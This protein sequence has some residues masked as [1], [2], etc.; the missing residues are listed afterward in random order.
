MLE[1]GR[2]MRRP[3]LG[4]RW[5][6]GTFVV[7]CVAV[8]CVELGLWQLRR[9][10][11]RRAFNASVERALSSDA[12]PLGDVLT[13]AGG[14]AA[15][16]AYRRVSASGTYDEDREVV[17]FG[18]TLDGEPGNEL[19]TP[20]V[21]HGGEAI[22]VDRGWVPL[23]MQT[24]PVG[25]A[26]PPPGRVSVTGILWPAEATTDVDP[27]APP[28]R[29]LAKVDLSRLEPQL[30]YA[31]PPVYLWLRSQRP[32]SSPLPRPVPL[33]PLDEGPHLSYAVQW[34]VFAAVA[35]VGFGVLVRRELTRR[36]RSPGDANGRAGAGPRGESRSER[37][38]PT[39]GARAP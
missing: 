22:V 6:V 10:A 12:R 24:P 38:G 27:S 5:L 25:P 9:L 19:L 17:L 2:T 18:R 35:V 28:V 39:T 13:A 21:L 36:R 29:Q 8:A 33:P 34:F 23:A 15:R 14:E 7:L 16:L 1:S 3:F 11:E 4:L 37:T 32:A 31:I 30:P 20:L 26:S